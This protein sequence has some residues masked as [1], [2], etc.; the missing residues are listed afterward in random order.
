MT[1]VWKGY[2]MCEHEYYVRLNLSNGFGGGYGG[3]ETVEL[4]YVSGHRAKSAANL[5]D[6]RR[7]FRRRYGRA[8]DFEILRD[9]CR[10]VHD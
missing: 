7:E 10:L 9:T 6:A 8:G 5:E 1:E 3:R 2:H 4:A